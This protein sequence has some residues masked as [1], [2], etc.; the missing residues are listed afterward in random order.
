[1]VTYSDV[2]KRHVVYAT[3]LLE[4]VVFAE[5]TLFLTAM[6]LIDVGIARWHMNTPYAFSLVAMLCTPVAASLCVTLSHHTWWY[7]HGMNI[8]GIPLWLCPMHGLFA[9]WA[10]DAYWL[11][12]LRDVRKSTLPGSA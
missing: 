8:I 9:H 6:L 10:L 7:A 2:G 3:A 1:M 5:F 12:T 11:V 4:V